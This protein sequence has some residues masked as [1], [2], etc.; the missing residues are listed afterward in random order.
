MPLFVYE[1]SDFHGYI[2]VN[3]C[4]IGKKGK[5]IIVFFTEKL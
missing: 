2:Q 4:K 5:I 3:I 1:F